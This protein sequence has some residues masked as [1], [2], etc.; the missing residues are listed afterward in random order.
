MADNKQYITQSHDNGSVMISEDVISKIVLHS[1]SDIEGYAGVTS[2]PGMDIIELI[3]GRGWG[4]SIK[5]SISERNHLNVE[6]NV[7]IYYGHSV[8]TVADAVQEAAMN[9]LVSMTGLEKISVHV[10]VCGIVRQ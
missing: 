6:C 8:M 10:N 4:K 9:A 2:K 5:V 7:L 3:G 1:L